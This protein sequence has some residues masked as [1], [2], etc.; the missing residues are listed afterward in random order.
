MFASSVPVV[1]LW[2]TSEGGWEREREKE[3]EQEH[4]FA[5]GNTEASEAYTS[6]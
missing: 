3:R 4:L 5:D 1:I 2:P 6:Y